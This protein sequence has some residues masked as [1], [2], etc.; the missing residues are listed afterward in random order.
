MASGKK[1]AA[2]V[3]GLRMPAGNERGIA[4]IIAIVALVMLG[5]LGAFALSSSTT[6][7]RIAGNFR[8]SQEAF[9]AGDSSVERA[10]TDAVIRTFIRP[11]A[12]PPVTAWPDPTN[13]QTMDVGDNTA[14]VRV[15]WVRHDDSPPIGSGYDVVIGDARPVDYVVITS[16]GEGPNNTQTT[17]ESMVIWVQ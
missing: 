17:I 14:D 1:N 12:S 7:L 4:L 3:H 15:Q 6:E 13:Y 2:G 11:T 16:R 10:A 9:Y 5:M 8:N